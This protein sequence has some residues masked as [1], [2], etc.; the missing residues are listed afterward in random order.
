MPIPRM[1]TMAWVPAF[2]ACENC[3]F[4]VMFCKPEIVEM[5]LLSRRL[6]SK[7]DIDNGISWILTAR[8]SAW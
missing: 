7:A 3:R 6:W 8:F 1:V 4:G 2:A 5:S